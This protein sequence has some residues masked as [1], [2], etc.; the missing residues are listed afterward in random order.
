MELKWETP[1]HGA[2]DGRE[3]WAPVLDQLR[4]RPGEWAVIAEDATANLGAQLK[5]THSGFEF[6]ARGVKNNRAEKVYG[7]YVGEV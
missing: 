7:R 2:A 1:S 4:D 3:R 6:T 5:R